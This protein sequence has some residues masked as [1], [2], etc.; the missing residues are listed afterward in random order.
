MEVRGHLRPGVVRVERPEDLLSRPQVIHLDELHGP[1]ELGVI[2]PAPD[3]GRL[4]ADEPAGRLR[5]A[6]IGLFHQVADQVRPDRI[7]IAEPI[8]QRREIEL[9]EGFIQLLQDEVGRD[10]R[11]LRRTAAAVVRLQPSLIGRVVAVDP[12]GQ[13]RDERAP[14]DL[15]VE[16]V[17]DAHRAL[18]QG[19]DIGRDPGAQLA[20]Q[21]LVDGLGAVDPVT[22]RAAGCAGPPGSSPSTPTRGDAGP[23]CRRC[24]RCRSE[25]PVLEP[26]ERPF[27]VIGEP[28]VEAEVAAE[29]AAGFIRSDRPLIAPGHVDPGIPPADQ[30]GRILAHRLELR[31]RGDVA[32]IGVVADGR[33]LGSDDGGG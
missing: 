26:G 12:P 22:D 19:R 33:A 31:R 21:P 10:E 4:A 29:P 11:G 6:A 25:A 15:V 20:P 5:I 30:E 14:G 9:A 13:R 18:P 17:C 16:R 3:V 32:A 1:G 2:V 24:G 27:A 7:L 8:Q 23:P 28:T